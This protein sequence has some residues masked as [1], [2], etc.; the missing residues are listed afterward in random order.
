MSR[1]QRRGQASVRWTLGVFISSCLMALPAVSHSFS[2][3]PPD[4]Y[5]GAPGQETCFACHDGFPL[6]SGPGMFAINAPEEFQG[7]GTYQIEVT[8]QQS[9]QSRWGFEFTPLDVGTCTITDTQDTQGSVSGGN[10]YVKHTSQGTQSGSSGPVSWSFDWTAP[11]DPPDEVIFYAAGNAANGNG[12][13]SGDYVY[14]AFATSVLSTAAAD[15]GPGSP[16]LGVAVRSIPNPVRQSATICYSIGA[17]G[18]AT[19]ALYDAEGRLVAE[20]FSGDAPA[21][22]HQAT[23]HGTDRHGGPAPAGLYVCRL[24]AA[25]QAE[26]ARLILVR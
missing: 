1:F 3:G 2:N 19:L 10:S 11:Q 15:G 4:G 14:T 18:P 7:G 5:T 25:G 24:T 12:V 13:T 26:T 22:T 23:W 16:A 8:L 21:G 9:G 17:R 20:L 6:N